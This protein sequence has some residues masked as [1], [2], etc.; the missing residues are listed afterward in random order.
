MGAAS[1]RHIFD[2]KGGE[3]IKYIGINIGMKK[4]AM[5]VIDG[6]KKILEEA[7]YDNTAKDAVA[8]A[9]KIALGHDTC[10]AVCESTGNMWIKSFEAFEKAGIHIQLANTLKLNAVSQASV[11]TDKIDAQVLARL[12]AADMIPACHVPRQKVRVQKQILRHRISLVQDRT[13]VANRTVRLLDK[14]D[15]QMQGSRI[16]GVK[17]MKLLAKEEFED[18]NDGFAVRQNIREISHINEEIRDVEEKIRWMALDNE[19]A[20]RIMYMTGLDTF[21]ATLLALEIDG[22]RRF[23]SPKQRVSCA[24]LCPTVHQSGKSVVA[25]FKFNHLEKNHCDVF[26]I[27]K[28]ALQHSVLTLEIPLV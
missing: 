14:Y 20:R 1:I 7:A 21:G 18:G 23:K 22:T 8:Y 9:K 28:M 3:K 5:C 12:L 19:D 11:K 27:L 4:C 15:M 6:G 26:P 2:F 24:G 13:K 16:L 25:V 17:N 10:K